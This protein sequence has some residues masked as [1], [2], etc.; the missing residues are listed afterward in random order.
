ML[1][2]PKRAMRAI[3]LATL[4]L[5][6][7]TLGIMAQ[8][9]AAPAAT[10]TEAAAPAAAV[11]PSTVVA[12]VSGESIT[13]ADLVFA[14]E[15]MAQQLARIPDA[16]RRAVLLQLLIDVKVLAAAAREAGLDQSEDFARRSKFLEERALRRA[17]LDET[18]AGLV[19]EQ[20]V[21]AEYD[22][23]LTQ[24]EPAEEI[25]AS[26]IL[27]ETEEEATAL[28]AEIDAGGDF[29][30][31]ATEN[32]IDPGSGQNG[33]E[34]GFFGRGA[35]VPA[36]DEA[37]FALANPGDVSDIVQSDFG[38]HIIKLNE[39]RQTPAPSFEE[40]EPQIRQFLF[41]RHYTQAIEDEMA[42]VDLQINDAELKAKF[43][44]LA[45]AQEGAAAEPA[46]EAPAAEAPAAQ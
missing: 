22:T 39:K 1:N 13:E 7:P 27:V 31:L 26:H 40:L 42:G 21:R 16:E 4:M 44:A 34:L 18:I 29:A 36:F 41:E 25:N 24:F 11:D 9:A 37:A 12:T 10:G 35:M 32:S 43:D 2:S 28:K 3:S 20:E 23:F 30:A 15:D 6:V 33:G 14:A 45:A 8:D 19:T 5:A 46:A 38:F 17:Y